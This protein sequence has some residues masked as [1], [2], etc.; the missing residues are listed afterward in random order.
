MHVW[1]LLKTLHISINI[2][3]ISDHTSYIKSNVIT[4]SYFK[5]IWTM[6]LSKLYSDRYNRYKLLTQKIKNS[7][8]VL[9]ICI[10]LWVQSLNDVLE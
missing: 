2:R 10:Y 8:R 5:L 9:W 4:E 3:I 1:C 6:S 7:K